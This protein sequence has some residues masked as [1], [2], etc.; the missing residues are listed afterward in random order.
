MKTLTVPPAT[1]CQY[2]ASSAFLV[3]PTNAYSQSVL[4]GDAKSAQVISSMD[5]GARTRDNQTK[6]TNKSNSE[7][8]LSHGQELLR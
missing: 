7:A 1:S 2:S 3:I 8:G 4:S 6:I 5:H